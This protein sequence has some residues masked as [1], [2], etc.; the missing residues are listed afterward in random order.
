MLS[1]TVIRIGA[2]LTGEVLLDEERIHCEVGIDG[3]GDECHLRH[4]LGDHSVIDSLSRILTPRERTV[5]L[6]QNGWRMHRIDVV[7]TETVDDH[8][9]RLLLVLGHL[10]LHHT[11][12]ARDAVVEVVGMSGTDVGDVLTGLRPC[13]GIGAVGVDDAA[14]F[15]ELTIEHQVGGCIAGRV[16]FAIDDFARLEVYHH[17]IGSFHYVVVDT[18]RLDDYEAVF[19]VYARHIAPSEDHEV[20]LHEVEVG[21]KYFFF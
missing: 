14:Q 8:H 9:T 5:I 4:L 16:Q 7:A 2:V 1:L 6:D 18:R 15:G 12:G 20:V 3:V 11:V 10:C 19:T 17:H 13:G 21:L